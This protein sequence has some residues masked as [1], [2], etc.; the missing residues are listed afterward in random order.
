M[1]YCRLQRE[2]LEQTMPLESFLQEG[3]KFMTQQEQ[4]CI[5]NMMQGMDR[6]SWQFSTCMKRF[7]EYYALFIEKEILGTVNGMYALVM[8]MVEREYGNRGEYDSADLY[9]EPIIRGCLRL[10][11]LWRLAHALYARW[12]NYAERRKRN[13]PDDRSLD[14]TS[15]LTRCLVLC[16]MAGDR[17]KVLFCRK[18]LAQL[19]EAEL[20]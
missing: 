15:E 2:A 1:E 13:I 20:L 18:K 4:T 7:E 11:K 3:E 9:N 14:G 16:E 10:R 5:Q 19:Q 12:W 8:G 17:S 6:G